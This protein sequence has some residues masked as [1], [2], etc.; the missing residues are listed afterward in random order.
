VVLNLLLGELE[1]LWEV[2]IVS[3]C[4]DKVADMI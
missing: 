1:G 4:V 2:R 3:Y